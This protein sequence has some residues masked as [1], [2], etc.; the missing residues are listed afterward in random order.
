MFFS[1][2]MVPEYLL[3]RDLGLMNSMFAL[4]LPGAISALTAR[5]IS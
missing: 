2:G 3:I 1:G 5:T 4:I